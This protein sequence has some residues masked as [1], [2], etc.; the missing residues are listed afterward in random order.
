M[1]INTYSLCVKLSKAELSWQMMV[2]GRTVKVT[3]GQT[4]FFFKSI[5][6]R[7]SGY[8]FKNMV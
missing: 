1:R 3:K 8:Q 4:G 2:P 5:E 6:E 7:I